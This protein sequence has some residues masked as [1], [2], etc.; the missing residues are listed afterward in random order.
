MVM[1][2]E[3]N[4]SGEGEENYFV[5]MTDMMVGILFIFII[6]LMLFALDFRR[7]TDVQQEA[8]AAAKNMARR[9]E[10]LVAALDRSTEIRRQLLLDIRAQ[11]AVE[12]LNVEIDEI[13]GV[14]RLTEDAV[15]FAAD[16][17]DLVDRAR[18]NVRRVARVL[19]RVLPRYVACEVGTAR[20]TCGG[21]ASTV[22]TVFIEGHTDATGVADPDERDR[23][24]WELSTARA[25]NTYRELVA[26]SPLLRR[27]R[28]RRGEEVLSVSGY[29]STRPV[30][31]R[32]TR[33]AWDKNRRIDLR[34][35]MEVDNQRGLK[36]VLRLTNAMR[37]EIAGLKNA[38]GA[39]R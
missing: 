38:S 17:A 4:E 32:E 28:N 18:D 10:A 7:T 24:N 36:E 3:G 12:R 2:H 33:E 37:D 29:S 5:S 15:R 35:V 16:Q 6:M 23:R 14:L 8:L 9:L 13:N 27:L 19:G 26:V 22:G 11:L 20:P 1:R 31:G 21:G 25:V 30:D 34:F 39:K